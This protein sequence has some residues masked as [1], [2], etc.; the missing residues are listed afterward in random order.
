MYVAPAHSSDS[1][2]HYCVYAETK[3]VPA[4]T[5]N[6]VLRE[7]SEAQ[8]VID[9]GLPPEGIRHIQFS[10]RMMPI[11]ERLVHQFKDK[12]KRKKWPPDWRRP[13]IGA[14]EKTIEYIENNVDR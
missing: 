11:C 13:E 12:E 4:A 3:N 10:S 8:H 14:D 6:H 7:E 9:L 5:T 2:A 1:V